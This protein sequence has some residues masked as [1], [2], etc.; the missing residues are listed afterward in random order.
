MPPEALVR[1]GLSGVRAA[2]RCRQ[3]QAHSGLLLSS[4]LAREKHRNRGKLPGVLYCW[5]LA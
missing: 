4:F 1:T 2:L 5:P 3:W